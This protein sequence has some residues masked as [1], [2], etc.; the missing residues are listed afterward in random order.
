MNYA[1]IGN[2]YVTFSKAFALHDGNCGCK[3]KAVVAAMTNPEDPSITSLGFNGPAAGHKCKGPEAIGSCGCLHAE[4]LVLEKYASTKPKSRGPM[5][6]THSPCYRCAEAIV[7]S[8]LVSG[9]FY[10]DLTLHAPAGLRLLDD[11]GLTHAPVMFLLSLLQLWAHETPSIITPPK[12]YETRWPDYFIRIM[13][14]FQ[15]T[16]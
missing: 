13:E 14:S 9:V 1:E 10:I 7:E 11:C 16:Q 4:P 15:C 2:F 12:Q 5:L 6:C 3:R 8:N